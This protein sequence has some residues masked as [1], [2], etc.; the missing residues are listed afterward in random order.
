MALVRQKQLDQALA[1]L[2]AEIRAGRETAA[3]FQYL[4]NIYYM[5]GDLLRARDALGRALD[6]EPENP[7]YKNNLR[8][9]DEAIRKR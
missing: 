3:G 5:Q 7:P 1:L 6:L 8:A 2:Q 4:S 9:L